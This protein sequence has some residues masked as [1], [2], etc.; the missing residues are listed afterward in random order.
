MHPSFTGL[1][2]M[3]LILLTAGGLF[4]RSPQYGRPNF[5]FPPS[6]DV[7]ISP[8]K[9]GCANCTPGSRGPSSAGPTWSM[10]QGFDLKTMIATV[11][12]VDRNHVDL[13]QALDDGKFYDF[14]L[15]LPEEETEETMNHLIEEGIK[16]Q[17]QITMTFETR[18][19]EVYVLTAPN[20]K[21]P[22][23]K[24]SPEN[25][26]GGGG[27][28][29]MGLC[30][31]GNR[32]KASLQQAGDSITEIEVST[33]TMEELCLALEDSL[34]RLVV[35]ETHL[36]GRYSFAVR[37]NAIHTTWAEIL[38]SWKSAMKEEKGKK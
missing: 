12:K 6:Y 29:S 16:K 9:S 31:F 30:C 19:M 5:P 13:P 33:N 7:H 36:K 23:L 24:S 35:D 8:S 1:I 26:G 22:S 38:A 10:G 17:F 27:G 18:P 3:N 25:P 20:G 28:G 34:D 37:D 11:Y 32:G 4:A 15:F 14:G 21:S 2:G